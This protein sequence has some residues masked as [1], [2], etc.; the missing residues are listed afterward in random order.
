MDENG[1]TRAPAPRRRRS[2]RGRY[3]VAALGLVV[4]VL[5]ASAVLLRVLLRPGAGDVTLELALGGIAVLLLGTVGAVVLSARGAAPVEKLLAGARR[6]AAGELEA[7]VG[8]RTGDELEEL[9]S[10][11][12]E[13]AERIAGLEAMNEHLRLEVSEL[14]NLDRVKGDLLANV[15]HELRTPL[16]AVS[17]YVEAM[18]EGLLGELD[19]TQKASLEVVERNIR[20]LRGTIEQLLAYA[21]MESGRLLAEP[22]PFD[23]RPLLHQA[24]DALSAIY[25]SELLLRCEIPARLPEVYADP[26]RIAE[27]VDNLLTNAVKFS[28]P[29]SPVTLAAREAA[30]G[31]EVA[32][33]DRGVGIAPEVQEKVF[34]RFYQVDASKKRHFGGLGLGLAIVR[35]VLEQ[36]NSRIEIES[37]EGA[38]STFRF[39]LPLASERSGGVPVAGRCVVALI[40]GDTGFL[41]KTAAHLVTAGFV[42]ETAATAEQGYALVE[43]LRPDIIVLERMLPD[44]DGFDLLA[45]FVEGPKT[46]RIP[47]VV[48]TA[49]PERALG[50]RLGAAEY[51]TKP[52]SPEALERTLIELLEKR[53][54]KRPGR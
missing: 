48:A 13:T 37:L 19:A 51:L 34:E 42:V 12:D 7:G 41:R 54:G 21:R 35:E 45:R 14:K 10:I 1:A 28:P 24:A 46:R 52:M 31:V 20:R 49:R 6:L 18:Q 38:G 47:V 40:D 5:A 43:R 50:L 9:G 16:T 33:S 15:S 4:L 8:V 2:L 29:G 25:G 23:L 39:V 3:V 44:S 17:G 32:V 36:N 30:G 27:V 22:R 11:L 53:D 26:G